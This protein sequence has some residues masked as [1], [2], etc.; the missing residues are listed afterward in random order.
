MPCDVLV[1]AHSEAGVDRAKELFGGRSDVRI[2]RPRRGRAAVLDGA[3]AVISSR[4]RVAYLVDVGVRTFWAAMVAR[5]MRVPSIVDTGD[6]VYALEKSRGGRSRL[7]LAA[8]WLGE[9]MALRSA[10]HVV[11]RGRAHLALVPHRATFIPDLAPSSAVPTSGEAVRGELGWES[12]FVVGLVGSLNYS[13]RLGIGYGWDLLEALPQM[14]SN[15]RALFVGDGEGRAILESR[16]SQLGVA[17]RCRFVGRVSQESV[18]R[19]IAAMDC[20]ISTQTNDAVGAVRTTGKLPLYLACGCPVLATDVG[21]AA[22]LLGPL[23]WTI[24]YHGVVDRTYPARLGAAI[25]RWSADPS[26]TE[27]R[28]E[29]ALEIYAANFDRARWRSQAWGLIGELGKCAESADS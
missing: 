6:A 1:I 15:V 23:G 21:E 8:V 4:P 5:I 29:Q 18:H 19:W 20:A 13:S 27:A 7:G 2:I 24:P 22:H 25:G 10:H 17:E 28:R 14:S 3:W 11:V 9:Q 26:G 16:A 12:N